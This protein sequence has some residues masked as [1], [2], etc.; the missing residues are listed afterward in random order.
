MFETT[1]QIG[2]IHIYIYIEIWE[3]DDLPHQFLGYL[4]FQAPTLELPNI[5]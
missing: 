2:Y 5:S 1:N 4:T 3:N